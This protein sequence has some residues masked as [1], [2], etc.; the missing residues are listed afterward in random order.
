MFLTSKGLRKRECEGANKSVWPHKKCHL[1]VKWKCLPVR[2]NNQQSLPFL[3]APRLT[4]LADFVQRNLAYLIHVAQGLVAH[5]AVDTMLTECP[6][7]VTQYLA[8]A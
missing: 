5:V 8:V 3:C 4:L 7:V 2:R 1:L 6:L